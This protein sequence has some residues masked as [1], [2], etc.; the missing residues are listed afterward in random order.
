MT[1][2][3]IQGLW[4]ER[5]KKKKIIVLLVTELSKEGSQKKI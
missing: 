5:N 2:T 1:V 3:I 4:K